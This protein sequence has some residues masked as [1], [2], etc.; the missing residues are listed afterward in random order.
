MQKLGSKRL[1]MLLSVIVFLGMAGGLLAQDAQPKGAAAKGTP[2][3]RITEIVLDAL[4]SPEF[5]DNP[6]PQAKTSGNEWLQ[7]LIRYETRGKEGWL[8]E[9]Q[10]KC[11][12]VM[13]PYKAG[14]PVVLNA[15]VTY[16]DVMDGLHNAVLYVRPAIVQR[17]TGNKRIK[18]TNVAVYV[19]AMAGEG[20]PVVKELRQSRDIPDKWWEAKEP[21]VVIRD[22]ELLPPT[23]TP[24]AGFDYDAYE[25]LRVMRQTR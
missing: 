18:K 17:Y 21:R 3:V 10:L 5:D 24:F 22:N 25:H 20:E 11:H 7:V 8:D 15:E 12:A 14:K 16:L 6:K 23:E 2:Q 4:P 1:V 13:M 9:V 19:E